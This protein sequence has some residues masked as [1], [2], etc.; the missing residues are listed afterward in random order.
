[1]MQFATLAYPNKLDQID[2]RQ[3]QMQLALCGYGNVKLTGEMDSLTISIVKAFQRASRLLVDGVVGPKTWWAL[4]GGEEVS[5]LVSAV[6]TL[7]KSQIG[8]REYP[9]N[10]NRGPI[11]DQYLRSCGLDPATGNYP[12]CAAFVEWCFSNA[13]AQLAIKSPCPKTAGCLNLWALAGF[14][15]SGLKRITA[16]EAQMDPTLVRPGMQMILK[17]S[18]TAGHTGLISDVSGAKWK[19]IEG[20]SNYDGSRDGNE[21]CL[22]DKR[23]VYTGSLL[24]LID[25]SNIT[26]PIA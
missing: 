22:Q 24:G 17:L 16:R 18:D 8:V 11:V 9:L 4:F 3:I 13:A 19:T 12:W 20:N 25:Y 10:S 14:E 5:P 23:S 21:V 1:M 26:L 15:Q 6:L 2:I 7:A